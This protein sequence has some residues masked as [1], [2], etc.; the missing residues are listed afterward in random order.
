[1]ASKSQAREVRRDGLDFAGFAQ[2]FLRRNP[3][4]IA[5][6]RD[7]QPIADDPKSTLE[8]EVMAH[9]WGLCF[10]MRAGCRPRD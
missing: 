1:M 9:N 7:V 4:Y 6:Y 2:E 5:E 8:L 10:S 3:D